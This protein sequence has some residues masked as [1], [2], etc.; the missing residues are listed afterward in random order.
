[1]DVQRDIKRACKIVLVNVS[2]Y[3]VIV[4]R[5]G[6][7]TNFR[8]VLVFTITRISQ[9]FGLERPSILKIVI[10]NGFWFVCEGL[11][12]MQFSQRESD[13]FFAPISPAASSVHSAN[14]QPAQGKTP[15]ALLEMLQRGPAG[16]VCGGQDVP[17]LRDLG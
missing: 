16:G 6:K 10:F 7:S 17:S 9:D 3:L 8:N 14:A 11:E 15:V 13:A 1:M 2:R 12:G 4:L 5:F